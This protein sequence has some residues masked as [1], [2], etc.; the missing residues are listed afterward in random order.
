MGLESGDTALDIPEFL[1]TDI[2]GKTG[3]GDII[4]KEFQGDPVG[5][6]RRLAHGYIGKGAGVDQAGIVLSGTHQG[7]IDGV[8]HEGGHGIAHFQVA[9]G[10]RLAALVKGYGDVIDPL[11]QVCQVCSHGQD[12]HQLAAHG[13]TEFRLHGKTVIAAADADDD[14]PEGLSAEINDPAHLHP[15]GINIKPTHTGQ[16]GQLL[17]IIITL[18]LHAG[19]HGHHGQVMSVHDI[20]DIT[21][22]SQRELSHGNQQGVAAAGRR[23]FDVHGRAAA[24]LTQSAANI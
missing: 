5:D 8:A 20:I 1:K 3:L 12:G 2:S 7:W 24:W 16:P 15:G 11:F 18:M 23:T 4:I 6:D 17:I 19:G 21:G 10:Y 14:I 22:K 13:N 9:A